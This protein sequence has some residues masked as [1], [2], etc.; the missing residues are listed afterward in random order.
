[1][2]HGGMWAGKPDVCSRQACLGRQNE[3]ASYDCK[4]GGDSRAFHPH[5]AACTV[6][7]M[8]QLQS[9]GAQPRKHRVLKLWLADALDKLEITAAEAQESKG[10]ASALTGVLQTAQSVL[11][12]V[13]PCSLSSCRTMRAGMLGTFT[14]LPQ[15]AAKDRYC[16]LVTHPSLPVAGWTGFLAKLY[17]ARQILHSLVVSPAGHPGGPRHHCVRHRAR[18]SPLVCCLTSVRHPWCRGNYGR[19]ETTGWESAPWWRA[20]RW[21]AWRPCTALLSTPP[22]L[23]CCACTGV[24]VCVCVCVCDISCNLVSSA[25]DSCLHLLP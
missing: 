20:G 14:K 10:I 15:R 16:C 21:T 12:Q 2:C 8:P 4:C 11:E 3:A 9:V 6:Q 18:L 25:Q 23:S 1:M 19:S 22:W 17:C 13:W 7:P 24:C 5:H